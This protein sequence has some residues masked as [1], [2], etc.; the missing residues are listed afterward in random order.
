MSSMFLYSTARTLSHTLKSHRAD[1]WGTNRE[2]GGGRPNLEIVRNGKIL[3]NNQITI[4][5]VVMDMVVV[6]ICL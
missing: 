2:R 3:E 6:A 1:T 4:Y 5:I